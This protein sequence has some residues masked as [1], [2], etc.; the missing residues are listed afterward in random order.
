MDTS[1]ENDLLDSARAHLSKEFS[2]DPP[3]S[4]N[5][6]DNVATL[7]EAAFSS[8]FGYKWS[9]PRCS[10]LTV[11]TTSSQMVFPMSGYRVV[12]PA[13]DRYQMCRE[14]MDQT[15]SGAN[16]G[17]ASGNVKADILARVSSC[18]GQPANN[19]WAYDRGSFYYNP[20]SSSGNSLQLDFCITF[21]NAAPS[22]SAV[23][24]AV[25]VFHVVAVFYTCQSSTIDAIVRDWRTASYKAADGLRNVYRDPVKDDRGLEGNLYF[26]ASEANGL[27]GDDFGRAFKDKPS[28][29]ATDETRPVYTSTSHLGYFGPF[30]EDAEKTLEAYVG[31]NLLGGLDIPSEDLKAWAKDLVLRECR[32]I[33][34]YAATNTWLSTCID[35]TYGSYK[36]SRRPFGFNAELVYWN[37]SQQSVVD[38]KPVQVDVICI[39][40]LALLYEYEA[41]PIFNDLYHQLAVKIPRIVKSTVPNIVTPGLLREYV[42]A[43][44]GWAF[45]QTYAIDFPQS[46]NTDQKMRHW[47]GFFE[48]DGFNPSRD[49]ICTAF[50][51]QIFP[52]DSK[53]DEQIHHGLQG[54]SYKWLIDEFQRL[55]HSKAT[56]DWNATTYSNKFPYDAKGNPW[57]LQ[58][59]TSWVFVNAALVEGDESIQ[60]FFLSLFLVS[61]AKVFRPNGSDQHF[62][63]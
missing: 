27:F 55:S 49:A 17:L 20:A 1:L 12:Q 38:R 23:A 36:N 22:G 5:L 34:G 30:K 33:M 32:T 51:Y 4:T 11:V 37:S 35:E 13:D 50:D 14:T 18:L 56:N 52:E 6:Q 46:P 28:N 26:Y 63:V 58:V 9:S 57:D 21:S 19:D 43:Y 25:H 29:A 2:W 41:D 24:S 16:L 39:Y 42:E 40:F 48:F 10:P 60:R 31:V 8:K 47:T 59:N 62:L 7:C 54:P 15:L 44:S 3:S 61:L 45:K 53:R